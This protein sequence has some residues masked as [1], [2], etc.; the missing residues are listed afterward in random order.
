MIDLKETLKIAKNN[1]EEDNLVEAYENEDNY[2]FIF[3]RETV[4]TMDDGTAIAVSKKDGSVKELFGQEM[5]VE[6]NTK[7]SKEIPLEEING[8]NLF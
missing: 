5:G 1:S 2:I 3:M 8:M 7:E 4:E 6:I